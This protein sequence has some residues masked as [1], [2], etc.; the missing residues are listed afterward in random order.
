MKF[1]RIF[2]EIW[3][4]TLCLFSSSTRNM[5]FGSDSITVAITS[6]ASSLAIERFL[7]VNFEPISLAALLQPGQDIRSVVRYGDHV[8]KMR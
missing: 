4:R 6:I 1:F 3:A 5:A 7:R 2:P 8:L